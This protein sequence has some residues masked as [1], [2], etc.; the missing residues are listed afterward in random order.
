MPLIVLLAL[1]G[2]G[3][4]MTLL[5][6]TREYLRSVGQLPGARPLFRSSVLAKKL[7]SM[8]GRLG[9]LRYLTC[10]LTLPF[11][12]HWLTSTAQQPQSQLEPPLS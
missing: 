4:T 11:G 10:S 6:I 12:T 7:G 2:F 8:F 3:G 1:Y 5:T 9:S